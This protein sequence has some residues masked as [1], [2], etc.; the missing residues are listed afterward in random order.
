MSRQTNLPPIGRRTFLWS[1]A[2]LTAIGGPVTGP[3]AAGAADAGSAAVPIELR[4]DRQ[5]NLMRIRMEMDVKGNVNVP[6]NP[7]VSRASDLTLPLKSNAIFDY[8]ERYLRPTEGNPRS[9]VPVVER[10]YHQASNASELN[11]HAST[12]QLRDSV[13]HVHVRRSQLPETIYAMEDY[14]T[15]DELSLLRVP[16]SSAAVDQLLPTTAVRVGD[17]FQPSK[18][19]LIS[20][21]NLSSVIS[22]DIQLQVVAIDE[23]NVRMQLRGKINGS[24]EGVPTVIRTVGKLTF[25]RQLGTS[26]WLAIALHETREIGKAEPGFDVAATIKMVRQPLPSTVALPAQAPALPL[27]GPPP[28]DRLYVDLQSKHVGIGVLLDRRWKLMND[29]PGAAMMRMIDGDHSIAQC[30]LRT[31]TSLEPGKQLTLEAFQRDIQRTLGDQLIELTE[32][33]Q[34]VSATG[35]RVLRVAARGAA[36]GVPIAWTML[37]F[38]DDSGRRVQATFTMSA[39][40]VETFAGADV[41]FADSLRLLKTADREEV[42]DSAGGAAQIASQT[43][44]S[45]E[46]SDDQVQSMSDLR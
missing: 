3:P 25:D 23:E 21:L 43:A 27:T 46:V 44:K 35:L 30:N 4:P 19:A 15:G 41:Q 40:S 36:E 24:V 31:L 28:E 42:A 7:L 34:R 17:T 29:V 12:F 16:I 8:E 11:R 9:E 1:A 38:S 37:H 26:T 39:D 20:L 14:F 22:S 6:K 13:R 32:A 10:F 2:L 5:R 18:E 33:E 45:D